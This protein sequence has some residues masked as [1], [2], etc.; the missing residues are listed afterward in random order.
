MK[1]K[2]IITSRSFLGTEGPHRQILRDAGYEV[3]EIRRDRPLRAAELAEVIIDARATIVGLDEVDAEVISRAE[4]LKVISRFGVGTDNVDLEAATRRRIVVTITPGANSV[5]VAELTIGLMLALT[6][7]IPYHDRLVKQGG[8]TRM[9]G[10]ELCGA[11]LGVIGMGRIGREVARR[12][13]AFGM[14]ILYYDIVPPPNTLVRKL[15]ASAR[16]LEDLLAQSDVVS[17]HTPLND[18]TR[19]LID[20]EALGRMKRS[21]LLINTA[22][23][24]LVDENALYDSLAEGRLA[25]AACDVFSHEPPDDSPLLTLENLIAMPHTGGATREASLRMGKMAVDNVLAVLRGQPTAYVVN[26]EAYE[27][28]RS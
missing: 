25:G 28:R 3:V 11:T 12:A 26:P 17:L 22:R 14:T 9:Q 15:Q 5:S 13:F 27:S 16:T 23:G 4:Q 1:D 19:N 6:R 7:H 24:G 8:W 21:A 10:M 18:E 2:V 20:R